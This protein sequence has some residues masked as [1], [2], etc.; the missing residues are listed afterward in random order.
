M[1]L[2]K[3]KDYLGNKS[4]QDETRVVKEDIGMAYATEH[5][6]FFMETSALNSKNV[7]EAFK[8]VITCIH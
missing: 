3:N 1:L 6:L 7:D 5:K 4:D 8:L 2:G